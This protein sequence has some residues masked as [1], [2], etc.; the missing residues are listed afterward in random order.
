MRLT[1][2]NFFCVHSFQLKIKIFLEISSGK[3][4]S[5]CYIYFLLYL[6]RIFKHGMV[7]FY[8]QL[9]S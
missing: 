2:Q 4:A 9:K 7:I 6:I 3:D 1:E 5:A 8:I